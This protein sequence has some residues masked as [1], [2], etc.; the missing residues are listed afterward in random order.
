MDM[1]QLS[2]RMDAAV[3]AL[4]DTQ[5]RDQAEATLI[6]TAASLLDKL[7]DRDLQIK[8]LRA[9]ID[10]MQREITTLKQRFAD[11]GK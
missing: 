11:D 1:Q 8:V 6:R 5:A 9:Q 10:D 4:L 7:S 2:D 3:T